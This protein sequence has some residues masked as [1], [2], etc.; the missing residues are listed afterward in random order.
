MKKIFNIFTA[1]ALTALLLNACAKKEPF[2][3][4]SEGDYPRILNTDFPTWEN[5]VPGVLSSIVR[6][7][8]F[9][10]SLVVTPAQHTSV[11]WY[12]D[13][14]EV[15]QGKDI[16]ILLEV[17]TYNGKVVATNPA[18]QST[19]RSFQV[20]VRPTDTDPVVNLVTENRLVAPS[21]TAAIEGMRLGSVAKL[22]LNGAD[23][24]IVSKSDDKI[25]IK[26]PD[27]MAAGEYSVT[28]VDAE[29][30]ENKAWYT[31][32]GTNYKDYT[33]IV[34][35]DPVVGVSE[36]KG[37]A[38]AD[39]T[40][41][42][43]NLQHVK[44]ISVNGQNAA[45]VSKSFDQLVFT[46]PAGLEPGTYDVTGV[47]DA[48]KP[49]NFNGAE[50][51]TLTVTNE[52][53]IFDT[54]TYVDWDHQFNGINDILKGMAGNGELAEGNIF[55]AYVNGSGVGA[56]LTSWW[57]NPFTGLEGE[58]NR[59]DKGIDGDTVLEYTLTADAIGRIAEQGA[60][61]VGGNYTINK[62]TLE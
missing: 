61:F 8:P 35:T 45:I 46:C 59:G 44:S 6:T 9:S 54:P 7:T 30:H 12:L 13:N 2:F 1:V 27:D 21:A 49:L 40:A 10:F 39:Y 24:E 5:G 15:A 34:S 11:V 43:I 22:K 60:I 62:V 4:A 32:D 3:T 47:D 53:V 19:S 16:E 58:A 31:E 51:A 17:G 26:I 14:Q 50:K 18:G 36:F 48:D 23:V 33:I 56:F 41:T 42:G 28:F 20:V 38:G 25:E 37:K 29:G 57:R 52:V 55:R